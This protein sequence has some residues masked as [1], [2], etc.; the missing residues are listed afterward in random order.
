MDHS[1]KADMNEKERLSF[2]LGYE[3]GR[4]H[5]R[6]LEDKGRKYP[7]IPVVV[8]PY[9]PR[10]AKFPESLERVDWNAVVKL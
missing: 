10:A 2:D 4:S 5:A 1:L 6:R 9:Q 7:V 3:L 8:T